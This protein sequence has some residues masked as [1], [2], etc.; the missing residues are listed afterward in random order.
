MYSYKVFLVCLLAACQVSSAYKILMA[1]YIGG[2]PNSH[3]SFMEKMAN[4]LARDNQDVHFLVG[5]EFPINGYFK[6]RK[7]S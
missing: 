5:E 3:R 7:Q 2:M 4:R 6:V 1:A